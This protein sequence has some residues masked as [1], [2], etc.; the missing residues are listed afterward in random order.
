MLSKLGLLTT[1]S[2]YDDSV[3]AS[4][5][6]AAQS[7][8]AVR[9][10][11]HYHEISKAINPIQLMLL[12]SKEGLLDFHD[13]SILLGNSK[14]IQKSHCILEALESKGPLAYSKFLSSVQAEKFHMGHEYIASLLQGK[15]FGSEFEL[16]ESLKLKEAVQR[17]TPEMMDICLTSLV[18]LICMHIVRIHAQNYATSSAN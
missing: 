10:R 9:V 11:Q 17:C 13:K 1:D 14:S 12:L 18:P 3:A 16:Q 4:N 6:K 7:E 15:S 5:T 8:I 2:P